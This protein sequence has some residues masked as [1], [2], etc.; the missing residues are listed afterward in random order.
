VVCLAAFFAMEVSL[1]LLAPRWT[2]SMVR[3]ARRWAPTFLKLPVLFCGL[4]VSFGRSCLR[5][6]EHAPVAELARI[7]D[8]TMQ[9]IAH[10]Q[11]I[12]LLCLKEFDDHEGTQ[13]S[14]LTELGYCTARSL[15]AC[16]LP[17]PWKSFDHYVAAM[18]AD[19]RR[20]VRRTLLSGEEAGLCLRKTNCLQP[21]IPRMVELYA[22]VMDRADHQLERLAPLFFNTLSRHLEPHIHALLVEQ[23]DLLKAFA[24]ILKGPKVD[25]FLLT[26]FDERV[27]AGSQLYPNLVL[28]VIKD[29]IESAARQLEMGQTSYPLKTRLGG[30]LTSRTI[31]LRSR[32]AWRHRLLQV[33]TPLLFPPTIT[34]RRRVFRNANDGPAP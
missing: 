11:R 13:L 8:A 2:R 9:Q 28:F 21:V 31:Y 15:P 27:S 18:R 23:D 1:D 6:R 26:G 12:D 32:S 5:F 4:P 17:L 20:Q 34:P 3:C 29:A 16:T 25:T 30:Q 19:Y 10:E 7:V 22:Q 14:C 24:L 33:A